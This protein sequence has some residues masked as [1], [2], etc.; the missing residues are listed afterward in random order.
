VAKNKF[1]IGDGVQLLSGSPHMTVIKN[2][3]NGQVECCWF[4]RDDKERRSIYPHAALVPEKIDDLSDE[5]LKRRTYQ[6]GA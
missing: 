4:D 6:P 5:E 1:K 3:K 2:L